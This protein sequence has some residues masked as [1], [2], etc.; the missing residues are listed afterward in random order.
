MIRVIKPGKRIFIIDE[1]E[2][3]VKEIYK[4]VPGKELYDKTKASIPMEYIPNE[5]KNIDSKI[6]CNGYMYIVSFDK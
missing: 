2:K 1:T 4:N 5:M 3:T 6:V